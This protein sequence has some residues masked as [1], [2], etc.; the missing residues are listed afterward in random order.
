MLLAAIFV[1]APVALIA[2]EPDGE[3]KEGKSSN[4]LPITDKQNEFELPGI[5]VKIKERYV[6]VDAE[7]AMT[8]GMLELFACTRET[9]EHESL[10]VIDAKAAHI[11][12]AL[13]LLG[14]RP[15]NPAMTKQV[16]TPEDPRWIDFP[17]RGQEI[18]VYLVTKNKEGE[19]REIAANKFLRKSEDHWE[20]EEKDEN[21]PSD[22]Q[23]PTHTFLFAGSH[24]REGGNADPVYLSDVSGNVISIVTFGDELLSL[25]GFHGHENS[26]LVWEVDPTHLPGVGE[27]VTLRLKPKTPKAADDSK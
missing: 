8:G 12:A 7:V 27:K 17:P 13:L 20:T 1:G 4:D 16:G 15:G 19:A 23:F 25:P 26:G 22:H 11:H 14:A 18:D 24:L 2:K 5:K 21:S 3:E 6:D 10:V 9:K